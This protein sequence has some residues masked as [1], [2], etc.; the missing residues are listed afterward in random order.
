MTKDQKNKEVLKSINEPELTLTVE[1]PSG[2]P[3]LMS[4]VAKIL[5]NYG[6]KVVS[7]DKRIFPLPEKIYKLDGLKVNIER[8]IWTIK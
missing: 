4:M 6:A 8:I 1:S 2:G 5:E 7:K 3:I